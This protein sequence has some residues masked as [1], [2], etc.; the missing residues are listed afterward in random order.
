[1]QQQ[2][3]QQAQ[4]QQQQVQQQA[5]QQPQPTPQPQQQQQQQA[6]RQQAVGA[7][8]GQS[9][10]MQLSSQQQHA[11]VS[12]TGMHQQAVVIQQAAG[13][14]AVSWQD[15]SIPGYYILIFTLC[16]FY[17][18]NSIFN[19]VNFDF[20]DLKK[21]WNNFFNKRLLVQMPFDYGSLIK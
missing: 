10:V 18:V 6:L 12:N 1:M 5:Q 16:R 19:W 20:S 15:S 2:Q 4:Q 14:N 21:L 11:V 8:P 7:I 17:S 13:P 9:S 3:Q